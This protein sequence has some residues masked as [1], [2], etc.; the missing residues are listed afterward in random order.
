MLWSLVRTGLLLFTIAFAWLV[1]SQAV[2]TPHF[3]PCPQV[4]REDEFGITR[5]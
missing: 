3:C 1:G 2:R 5:Q 4:G